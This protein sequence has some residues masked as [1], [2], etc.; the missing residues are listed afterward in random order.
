M[1]NEL[2]ELTA[3][4]HALVTRR[5][6]DEA[7]LSDAAIRHLID[8]ER[9]EVCHPGV[10][11][12]VGT[13]A[14]WEQKMLAAC[15]SMGDRAASSHRAA[16]SLWGL[17]GPFGGHVE[18]TGERSD[19]SRPKGATIHRS[20]DLT[21]DHITVRRRI[22]VTEPHR[23][24]V[25]LGAVVPRKVLDRAVDDALAKKLVTLDGILRMLDEVGRRGRRGVGPCRASVAERTDA[26]ESVLEAEFERLI[27]RSDLAVP[28]FQ[29]ELRNARGRFVARIDAAYED[30][31][32]A[33]ER[34]RNQ[35]GLSPA[36]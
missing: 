34:R 16:A 18:L 35:L 10:Y 5:Q 36:A 26:P 7:G 24:L 29:F 27:R 11:R 3:R 32:L 8:S 17:S 15:L 23:T 19:K 22:P 25:D 12:L 6:L 30:E 14:T 1:R 28:E 13:P 9:L 33:L 20:T 31:K 2:R 21:P 4:Q